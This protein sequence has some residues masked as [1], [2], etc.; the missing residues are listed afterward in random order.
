[1]LVFTK[2]YKVDFSLWDSSRVIYVKSLLAIE[3]V[4]FRVL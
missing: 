2:G 3:E 1:M 4:L